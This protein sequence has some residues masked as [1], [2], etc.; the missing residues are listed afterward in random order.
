M[1]EVVSN[2][3]QEKYKKD[4]VVFLIES[5]YQVLEFGMLGMEPAKKN[6]LDH[7]VR[8]DIGYRGDVESSQ[9]D[10]R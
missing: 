10:K 6:T 5:Y 4:E 7:L 2:N 3:S 8:R 9:F 1:V